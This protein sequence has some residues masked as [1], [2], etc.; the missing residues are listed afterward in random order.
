MSRSSGAADADAASH[1]AATPPG[2]ESAAPRS[3][4]HRRLLIALCGFT[5]LTSLAGGAELLRFA[6]TGSGYAP[7]TLLQG[8]PFAT[9]LVPGL[10]LLGVVGG[11]NLAALIAL[12]RRSALAGDLMLTAA[13]AIAVWIV[14]EAA[15]MRQFHPLHALYAGVALICGVAAVRAAW[16]SREPRLRWTIAVT[17]AEGA[18]FFGPALVGVLVASM[19]LGAVERAAALSLAGLWEGA[20]LG[21]GQA[22]VLPLPL[23]RGRFVLL[24]AAGGALVWAGVMGLMLL[25]RSGAG[26]LLVIPASI[27]VGLGALLVMGGMQWL[28]LRRHV[29]ADRRW[30]WIGWTALAW[31]LALPMS[32]LPGLLVDEKTPFGPNLTLWVCG[33]FLL[34]YVLSLVT[35]QGARRLIGPGGPAIP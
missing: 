9:F 31:V 6:G 23:R 20:W 16:S 15:L 13:G 28:E 30:I 25:G 4:L 22:R 29:P 18:G 32:F 34:A 33:G 17:A 3:L 11:T 8:T 26:A 7:L 35:W 19:Q 12:L 14:A 24:T 5:A 10:L 27:G 21:L 2:D 1:L